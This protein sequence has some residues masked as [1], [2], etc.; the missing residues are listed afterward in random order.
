MTVLADAADRKAQAEQ[1]AELVRLRKHA[2]FEP[3]RDLRGTRDAAGGCE[4]VSPS[5]V[6]D[7]LGVPVKRRERRLHVVLTDILKYFGWSAVFVMKDGRATD[8]VRSFERRLAPAAAA[9]AAPVP[10]TPSP[11]PAVSRDVPTED[12]IVLRGLVVPLS[13][14]VAKAFITDCSRVAEG[15]TTEHAVQYKYELTPEA[16]RELQMHL[17]L[18]RLVR[19]ESER[20]IRNGLAAQELAQKNMPRAQATL[21]EILDD[22]KAS[23][24]YRVAAA[25]ETR[26]AASAAKQLPGASEKFSITINFGSD[27]RHLDVKDPQPPADPGRQ[28]EYK[29]SKSR[30]DPE[31]AAIPTED[32]K[33]E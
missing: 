16:W 9:V 11:A 8:L 18:D 23:P 7:F 6:F 4:R 10:S 19:Q 20:R 3:L 5:E 15:V 27:V 21:R 33:E 28:L 31:P 24:G 12:T 14:E 22:P 30:A 1:D 17:P 2:F 26:E 25:K 32:D 13:N 29:D